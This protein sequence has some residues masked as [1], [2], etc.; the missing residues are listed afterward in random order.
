[1]RGLAAMRACWTKFATSA[2][3]KSGGASECRFVQ[4]EGTPFACRT[5]VIKGAAD[6]F[7]LAA[8]LFDEAGIAKIS[9]RFAFVAFEPMEHVQFH[10][11][12][13]A[14][15]VGQILSKAQTN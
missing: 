7:D 6:E 4:E 8:E 10:V 1:M 9:E 3:R 11:S 2:R 14:E 15:G 13:M 5:L 12:I